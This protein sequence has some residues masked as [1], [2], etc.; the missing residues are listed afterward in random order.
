MSYILEALRRAETE[1]ERRRRVPG[2]HA[3]PVPVTAPDDPAV[4]R[5]R[6]W[7]WVAIG[8]SAGVL[9]SLAWRGW[10]DDPPSDEAVGARAAV[11]GSVTPHSGTAS[12]DASADAAPASA[13]APPAV[14]SAAAPPPAAAQ[15]RPL[16]PQATPATPKATAV[17]RAGPSAKPEPASR[18]PNVVAAP[19]DDGATL[20]R[21]TKP[22]PAAAPATA[23]EPRLRSLAELPDDLK[24][25]VPQ[26]AFGGSVYSEIATQRM[27]I[28]NGQVLR[29]GDAVTEELQLEQIRP[30]S[31]VMRLRGQRFE[32][33]F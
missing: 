23:P 30:R 27:V 8:V 1:R 6:V 17:A 33:V 26:L 7:L 31:A 28:F 5:S 2:L 24:R 9:L 13:A 32:I 11:A 20:G 14:V 25:S 19:V 10:T 21:S 18:T 29:E 12:P 4:R 15:E 16:A 22:A 3:Q